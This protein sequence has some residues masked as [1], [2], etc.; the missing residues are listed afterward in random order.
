MNYTIIISSIICIIIITLLSWKRLK[1]LRKQKTEALEV[2][3]ITTTDHKEDEAHISLQL[4][5][6]ER[7]WKTE[8]PNNKVS[9]VIYKDKRFEDTSYRNDECASFIF[10][11]LQWHE[12]SYV[13]IWVDYPSIIK[14]F[15]AAL[16]V[17]GEHIQ[18]LFEASDLEELFACL[19]V[20]ER[21]SN[22]NLTDSEII[23]LYG[24]GA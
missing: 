19:D 9:V 8:H 1:Q 11:P 16:Y 14:R 21:K 22:T 20:L 23:E 5:E 18:D 24:V 15:S 12:Q 3:Q 17:S 6:N 7:T 4:S 2:E 10:K 13:Q